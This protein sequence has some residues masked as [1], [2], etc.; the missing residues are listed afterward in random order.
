MLDWPAVDFSLL[1]R[2]FAYLLV[3]LLVSLPGA[4]E[5]DHSRR[6]MG[7]RTLPLVAVTA[8]ALVLVGR[9][10][11]ETPEALGR[12]TQGLI[13]GIGF[14]GGGAIVKEGLSVHGT[15]TAASIWLTSAIGIAIGFGRFET[16]IVLSLVNVAV[17]RFL[18]PRRQSQD[19]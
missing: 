2:V 14:L 1:A 8:C 15:A 5:R 9:L 7:L 12:I 18:T 6:Q 16:G 13:T 10:E 4:W 11:L 17:L 19:D 3:A